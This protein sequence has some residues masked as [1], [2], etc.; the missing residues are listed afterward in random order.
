MIR[1]DNPTDI[2]IAGAV[3][4]SIARRMIRN[5]FDRPASFSCRSIRFNSSN[6]TCASTRI[7]TSPFMFNTA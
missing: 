4:P 5:R 2:A 7:T 3:H 6:D 1:L